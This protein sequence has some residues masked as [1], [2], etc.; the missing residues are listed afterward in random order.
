TP[1]GDGKRTRRSRTARRSTNEAD[2]AYMGG[3]MVGRDSATGASTA[4]APSAGAGAAAPA[5]TPATSPAPME[6]MPPPVR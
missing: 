3:G 5:M 4:P 6:P 1:V 2:R